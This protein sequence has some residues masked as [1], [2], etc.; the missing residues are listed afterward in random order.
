MVPKTRSVSAVDDML[1]AALNGDKE[2]REA[3][4]RLLDKQ[5]RKHAARYLNPYMVSLGLLDDI[6]QETWVLLL[7][8]PVGA[9]DPTRGSA[10]TY[11]QQLMRNAVQVVRARHAPVGLPVKAF[12]I[13]SY[14]HFLTPVHISHTEFEDEADGGVV[15]DS[16]IATGSESDPAEWAALL[17][18]RDRVIA[19]ADQA[20]GWVTQA[21]ALLAAE[22]PIGEVAVS[23][24]RSRFAIRRALREWLEE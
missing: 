14:D 9:Y 21:I 5:L 3:L 15:A 20:P 1:V 6:T 19:V 8:K 10:L 11:L 24:G 23:V 4:P 16:L 22:H 18:L 2:A 13:G 17:D 7:Q 12:A